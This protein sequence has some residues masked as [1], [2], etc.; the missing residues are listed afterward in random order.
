[1]TGNT[2]STPPPLAPPK[3]SGCWI[4][5]LRLVRSYRVG[6]STFFRLLNEHGSAQAAL[7]ALPD[8]ANKAGVAKYRPCSIDAAERELAKGRALGASLLA[9]GSAQY[10]PLL[11]DIPDAPPLLW[12]LGDAALAL[13]PTIAMVGARNASSLGQRMAKSLA[14]DLTDAGFCIVSGLARGI[15][16]SAHL[17]ALEGGTIAVQAGGI[18]QVYPAENAQLHCDIAQQ[19][20]RL[21]EQPIGLVPKARDFPKRN[22]IISGMSH[23]VLVVEAAA[24][25][26]SLITA[27]NA[28][29]QGRDVLVVPGHPMDGR[30]SGCN[31]LLRDGATLIR[32]AQDVLDAISTA[33]PVAM[34]PDTT[35]DQPDTS[36]PVHSDMDAHAQILGLLGPT[37]VPE[38]QMIRD[39]GM[40]AQAVSPYI[41]ELELDG[42][43]IRHPGG[44]LARA[45]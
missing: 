19:G 13:R 36:P 38:D 6:T 37:P 18:D 25:S 42:Q 26:G 39:M 16:T 45:I 31:M 12:A 20:L 41:T 11:H 35:D 2:L 7:E 29:D 43:I 21:S 40:G 10:P 33:T 5:W 8:I 23:A 28:L 44:M 34:S 1:M 30:S 22:R 15:D 24:K 17:A 3:T 4:S 14:H 32:N 27:R 9:Y